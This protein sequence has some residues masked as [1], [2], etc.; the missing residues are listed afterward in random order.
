MRLQDLEYENEDLKH[1]NTELDVELQ[2]KIATEKE[3][4]KKQCK[5]NDQLQEYVIYFIGH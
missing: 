5:L 3:N 4:H 2:K 1:R